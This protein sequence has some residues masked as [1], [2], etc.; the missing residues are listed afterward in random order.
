MSFAKIAIS[1]VSSQTEMLVCTEPCAMHGHQVM[2]VCLA[3]T[4][5]EEKIANTSPQN[6]V[7]VYEMLHALNRHSII[8]EYRLQIERSCLMLPLHV[9]AVLFDI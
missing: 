7:T 6:C 4:S 8:I 2:T 3:T 9:P 1:Q 5:G